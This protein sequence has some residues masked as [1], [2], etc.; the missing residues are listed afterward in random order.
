MNGDQLSVN[1]PGPRQNATREEFGEGGTGIHDRNPQG[2]SFETVLNNEGLVKGASLINPLRPILLIDSNA[3]KDAVR[4]RSEIISATDFQNHLV[5]N[6]LRNIFQVIKRCD[7]SPVDRD[8]K[9]A[10]IIG[11]NDVGMR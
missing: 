3:H 11:A 4:T 9:S 10:R 8:G 1:T 6:C 2:P 5:A 7:A